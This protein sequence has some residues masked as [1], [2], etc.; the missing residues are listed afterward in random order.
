MFSNAIKLFTIKGFDIKVDAS[1]LL[2][3][4][5]ITWGLSQHYYP[6]SFPGQSPD[7]YLIMSI[8]TMLCFFAS[9]V[10]HEI[11]HSV[12]AT[13]FGVPIAGITLF[14]FG[15]VAELKAEPHSARAE[16]WVALAGPAMSLTLGFGF[17]V[18]GHVA[19]LFGVNQALV[20]ILSYLCV[21][22]LVLALFNLV[23]AFPLDGGRILRAYLWHRD[24]DLLKATETAAKSGQIFAYMLMA[25]GVLSLVQGGVISG[26]WYMM[27]GAFVLT[28]SRS[29]YQTQ[30]THCVF[31]HK[32]VADLMTR[33]PI[34][35]A[36]NMTLD[37]FVAQIM[38]EYRI[39]FV[40]VVEN[41]VLLGHIDQS[42]LAGIDR[43]NWANTQVGDVFAGLDEATCVAPDM[44]VQDLLTRI[45]LSGRRKFLVTHEACLVGVITLADLTAYLNLADTLRHMHIKKGAS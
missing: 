25:L 43:E 30:L 5:L 36:P 42:V 15:G 24:K 1:W 22:N 8:V 18:L 10:L 9:L 20:E 4:A 37:E 13:H 7:T 31:A 35:A 34:V 2:I 29:S 21:I 14:L 27:I 26:V 40:P 6:T 39:S 17:W 12:V 45:A 41:G 16:F 32:A 23:P 33:T 3:A 19:Q 44:P 38:L 11:A 28:A